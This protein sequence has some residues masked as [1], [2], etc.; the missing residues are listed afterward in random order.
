MKQFILAYILFSLVLVGSA[1]ALSLTYYGIEG[2]INTDLSVEN[3]ITLEFGEPI[4][5][6]DYQL[7][8]FLE[9][10]SAKSSL[11]QVNCD[12]TDN[13]AGS[14]ISCDFIGM[15]E[16]NNQ[17]QLIFTTKDSVKRL[18]DKNRFSVNYGISLP[19]EEMFVKVKLPENSVLAEQIVNQSFF[20]HDGKTL[21][22]DGNRLMIY[23]E[24]NNITAGDNLQ[25][26]IMYASES[27]AL[28]NAVI[29]GIAAVIIIF[30]IA[31]AVYVKKESSKKEREVVKS[32]L[33]T[34]E[35]T[36]V[37]LL[38][39]KGGSSVQKALV[40]ETD[41]SKAKVS[42]I[43]KNLKQRG[44]VDIEPVSGRENRIIL[45]IKASE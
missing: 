5:H 32:V 2:A 30:M 17:L 22:G 36:I 13:V 19:V 38:M 34:D 25:Y 31:V 18:G 8:F 6:L 10:L 29:Y 11:E 43:I 39:S 27:S 7:G 4:A 40:R 35:N 20:P 14:V 42:R 9:N 23:W 33:N 44:V 1:Q 37:N 21:L 28:P 26:S 24:R 41:F 12:F 15:T 45:K 3:T 16:D